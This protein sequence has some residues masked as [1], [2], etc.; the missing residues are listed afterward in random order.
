MMTERISLVEQYSNKDVIQQV[1]LLKDN[2][3]Y[4]TE[5]VEE[6]LG[7]VDA[8]A[9]DAVVDV[10]IAQ[11][12][13]RMTL[14][15]RK[16]DGSTDSSV[17]EV[18]I[19]RM[20]SV[21][22][23]ENARGFRVEV[24]TTDGTVY[25]SQDLVLNIGDLEDVHLMGA[26]L[27]HDD[28]TGELSATLTMSNGS[29][30]TTNTV[31]V[32]VPDQVV[33][34]TELATALYDK[35]DKSIYNANVT[36]AAQDRTRLDS[37]IGVVENRCTAL[38]T[39]M[40]AQKTTVANLGTAVAGKQDR[41]TAG[42]NI[43]IADGVISASGG[44]DVPDNVLTTDWLNQ[45]FESV[46][47]AMIVR[48]GDSSGSS[49]PDNE[50]P[51][52]YSANSVFVKYMK[53]GVLTEGNI[54]LVRTGPSVCYGRV[55]DFAESGQ[56]TYHARYL[57]TVLDGKQDAGDYVTGTVLTQGLAGKQD[58]LT[59]GTGISIVD[60]VISVNLSNANGVSF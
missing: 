10:G 38:E 22:P 59:A 11:S 1:K 8:A 6:A 9:N 37:E 26:V 13:G 29:S 20:V 49:V 3:A 39:D 14:S 51:G 24:T 46:G 44:G 48:I 45:Q 55:D 34:E 47:P 52:F 23:V 12:G 17:T 33:T 58:A 60:G 54:G 35:V 42:E 27:N 15:M 41:L 18:P 53:D 19:V 43:T 40:T 21:V 4:L 2:D 56:V 5:K 28:A 30:F 25:R 16:V 32:G 57:N 7:M 36:A 31:T 50:H